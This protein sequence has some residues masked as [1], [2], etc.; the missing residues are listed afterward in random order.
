MARDPSRV[1]MGAG[2]DDCTGEVLE[3]ELGAGSV[4]RRWQPQGGEESTPYAQLV[5]VYD[6]TADAVNTVCIL[7]PWYQ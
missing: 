6:V 3:S 1:E 7:V 4:Q 2:A 5:F